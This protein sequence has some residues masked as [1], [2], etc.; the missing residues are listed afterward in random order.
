MTSVIINIDGLDRVRPENVPNQDKLVRNAMHYLQ[1]SL[2]IM[3]HTDAS[4]S[5]FG[6]LNIKK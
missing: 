4:D 6:D 3:S 2:H 5:I 1:S